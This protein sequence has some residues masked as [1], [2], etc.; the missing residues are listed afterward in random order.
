M[1]ITST[2]VGGA[3]R[4]MTGQVS[5][6]VAALKIYELYHTGMQTTLVIINLI[7]NHFGRAEDKEEARDTQLW[8]RRN[9]KTGLRVIT[10]ISRW[11][12]RKI[13]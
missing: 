3:A 2:P 5:T 1:E 12:P 4:F 7:R 10:F 11:V 8:E 13:R 6:G 9:Q